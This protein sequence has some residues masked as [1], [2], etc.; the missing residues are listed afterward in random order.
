MKFFLDQ[1][2]TLQIMFKQ[3]IKIRLSVRINVQIEHM[4]ESLSKRKG[5][6]QV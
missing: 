5:Q 4:R 6:Y 1:G 3:G 2:F